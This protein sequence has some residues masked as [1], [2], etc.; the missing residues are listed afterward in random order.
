MVVG[1]RTLLSLKDFYVLGVL[2]SFHFIFCGGVLTKSAS[3]FHP[4]EDH[5]HISNV[6]AGPVKRSKIIFF[7]LAEYN[8]LFGAFQVSS[9]S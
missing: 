9:Q 2:Q 3:S 1:L 6:L 4:I 8:L 5:L 7:V